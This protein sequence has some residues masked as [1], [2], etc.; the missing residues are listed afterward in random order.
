MGFQCTRT[1]LTWPA[2]STTFFATAKCWMT[3]KR[4]VWW[5]REATPVK[6]PPWRHTRTE[7]ADWSKPLSTSSQYFLCSVF[8]LCSESQICYQCPSCTPLRQCSWRWNLW[9][10]AVIF[11]PLHDHN[12]TLM[13]QFYESLTNWPWLLSW[14]NDSSQL[15][16]T[17]MQIKMLN[18][19][20]H[21]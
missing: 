11:S 10:L 19:M 5:S 1:S 13:E 15:H 7:L 12:S 8:R 9:R 6:P 16:R 17:A 14:G 20:D 3:M 2:T 4:S 18:A 21:P